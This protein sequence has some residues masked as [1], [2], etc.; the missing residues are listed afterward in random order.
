MS[1]TY[2]IL[3]AALSVAIVTLCAMTLW[4]YL[5]MPHP[6]EEPAGT[7]TAD[8]VTQPPVEKNWGELVISEFMEKNRA[9]L[10]DGD[11]D[12]S[13]WIELYNPGAEPV[14]LAGWSIADSESGAGWGFPDISLGGGEYLLVFASGKD[15]RGGELHTDFAISG[16]EG[17]YLRDG[18]GALRS[19]ALCL[20]CDKDVSVAL[21]A[22]GG[23][24]PSLYPTPGF[25]NSA[26]GYDALQQTLWPTGPLVINEAMSSNTVYLEQEDI[27]CTD[28]AEIKNISDG[29]VLLSDYWLSDDSDDYFLWQ[30]PALSLAPGQTLV[31]LC[32]G[33]A[34]GMRGGLAFSGLSL[35]GAN[36]QL[37]LCDAQG[38]L[39]DYM[40]LR[41]ISLNGSFGRMDGLPGRYYFAV[42]SPGEDNKNGYTRVSA[43]PASLEADGVFDGVDAVTVALSAAGEI[44]YTLDG[45][46]PTDS[47]PL[48]TAPLSVSRTT[49][50]RAVSFEPGALP[51]R[52]LN[53]SYIVNEGHSLPVVSLS[54]D[55]PKDFRYMYNGAKKNMEL[56]GSLSYYGEDGS[57]TIGC[58][59][60]LNGMTSLVL[61]KKNMSLRFRGAYG[62]P[63]L[64]YDLYGGGV[65]EFTNLLLR[66]GQDF[67]R[68][69]IRNELCH[70]LVALSGDNVINQRCK[71]VVLYINGEYSGIYA[72]KEKANEQ[73]YASLAGVSKDSVEL[74]EPL[75]DYQGEFYQELIRFAIMND[76]RLDESYR[77]ICE[78]VDIDS[79]IDFLIMEGFCANTDVTM[80]NMRFVRSP[81]ADNRW[82]FMIYD[83]DATFAYEGSIYYNLMSGFAENTVQLSALI[84]PLMKNADFRDAFLTRASALLRD[85]LTNEAVVDTIDRLCGQIGPEVARDYA[86]FGKSLADWQYDV[87]ELRRTILE[88][89]WRQLNIDALSQ[90]FKLSGAER[91]AYF[92]DM[93]GKQ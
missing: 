7:P 30:L 3:I 41:D 38:A 59:I 45:S 8:A 43:K 19:S 20:G 14:A 22:D 40:S 72:L 51:S 35:D 32:D 90:L 81:E 24:K 60:S 16:D 84:L 56:P 10:Q 89:D 34:R 46:L 68:A 71:Y 86:R 93:D 37:Y 78:R 26:S 29:E 11:G 77:H 4:L 67:D 18:S 36:E 47:S 33:E 61:E 80:G 44:R 65:T 52:P 88:S 64:E 39:V 12:M 54:S 69:I 73:L 48:Y 25:E 31:V 49:A 17:L 27:G 83:L 70:E 66:A 6:P 85:T 82:R 55:S 9:A 63:A 62:D 13:D 76:M 92:G 79:L 5:K 58:G 42:P 53:L 15:S 2:K 28:W 23:Y 50:L 21:A 57:F 87:D 91:L 75:V 74:L 1:R